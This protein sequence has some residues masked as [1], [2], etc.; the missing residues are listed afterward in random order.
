MAQSEF[1][2]I[3]FCEA[4]SDR[5]NPQS[6]KP[7][8]PS[9][10]TDLTPA[11]VVETPHRLELFFLGS[12]YATLSTGQEV[13]FTIDKS[14]LLLAYLALTPRKIYRREELAV[15]LY[16]DHGD[17]QASVNLR[18]ILLRLRRAIG[19]EAADPP[20]LIGTQLNLQFNPDSLF[21]LDALEFEANLAAVR[22][23]RHRRLAV[24]R[25]CMTQ[26]DRAVSLY[27]GDFLS[28]VSLR[29]NAFFADWL[30]TTRDELSRKA[31]W[32]LQNL[33]TH[34]LQRQRYPESQAYVNRLLQ[35]EPLN[36]EALRQ[37]MQILALQGQRN[38]ALQRYHDFQLKLLAELEVN[39]EPETLQLAQAIRNM[40]LLSHLPGQ[41]QR[42]DTLLTLQDFSATAL[43]NT[44][45]PFISRQAE[46][47]QITQGLSSEACRLMTL[48]G[49]GGV[50][51][52][53]LAMRAAADDAPA[54]AD[55]VWLVLLEDVFT[56]HSLEE[57][58]GQAL[59][60]PFNISLPR[61]SQIYNF[62]REKELLLVLDNFEQVIGQADVVKSILD[63]A[64]RVK[65]IVTSRQRL[66]IRGEQLI[67]IGGLD[68]PQPPDVLT[69]NPSH[70][71]DRLAR[72]GAIQL[73]IEH[74]RQLQPGFT[75]NAQNAE[76]I[77]RICQRLDGLP[78]G[79]ELAAAWVRI[80]SCEEILTRLEQNVDFL[81]AQNCDIPARHASL[82]A[83][84]EYSWRLLSSEERQ[85]LKKIA[86][87]Q[88]GLAPAT[89]A[90]TDDLDI[91]LLAV[92]RDKSLLQEYAG[93]RLGL[94]SQVRPFVGEKL[95]H[96]PI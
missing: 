6:S 56:G 69:I 10:S 82:R 96:E 77:M 89:I 63:H 30:T 27:R 70:P 40:Q 64:P 19:D 37:E 32:A 11:P 33:V 58:L 39:P 12:P 2:G 3:V 83:V 67:E 55:G 90:Q 28:G 18:Q 1:C 66:E 16:P 35:M 24:C 54:W 23:H 31:G 47:A 78:L 25:E 41:K 59:G 91:R 45:T 51:K 87:F 13:R 26:L 81:T 17:K 74:A 15:R 42:K 53:R 29:Q 48:I 43:P 49:P 72:Y 22:R 60:I 84:F 21:W 50:G 92:L 61:R 4:Q 85:A 38:L 79:I 62:L 71:L 7:M 76:A 8:T 93:G 95:S 65:V 75:F 94:H 20:Y 14:L 9:T 34:H 88:D 57:S 52:T 86:S 80:L 5:H 44:L 36:E 73:F 46:L 68:Y